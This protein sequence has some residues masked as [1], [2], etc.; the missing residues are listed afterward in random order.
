MSAWI[1]PVGGLVEVLQYKG[2]LSV[3]TARPS[4]TKATLGGRV[5]VQR[6]PRSRRVW[7]AS[8]DGVSPVE[9]AGLLSLEAGSTPPWV[10]VDP[11]AQVTNM[12][13][14]EQSVLSAGSW[15]GADA[16]EGGAAVTADGLLAVRTLTSLAGGS[17]DFAYR[18]GAP[19]YPAVVEGVPVTG[20]A[21]V[22][23]TG[24]V[25][26][27]FLDWSGAVIGTE[28]TATYTHGDLARASVTA[29]PPEGATSARLYV[30]GASQAAMPALTWTPAVAG[31]STGHGC[32]RAIVEGLSEAI[33]FASATDPDM[34]WQSLNFTVR[35]IG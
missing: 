33:E 23:G 1:G 12:L 20:S 6:G 21:Y 25:H 35:E 27:E 34:R 28:F 11:Y 2:G 7:S 30:T 9:A 16:Y 3:E 18:D 22:R 8:V 29:T 5:K 24:S 13:S 10:W 4:S 14:P 15:F 26:V 19:D 17:M 32:N 31:W